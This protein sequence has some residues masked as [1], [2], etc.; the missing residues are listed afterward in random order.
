MPLTSDESRPGT[1]SARCPPIVRRGRSRW[2][3][4]IG[5]RMILAPS[6]PNTS[7]KERVNF[8]SL[9]QIR[10]SRRGSGAIVFLDP[11]GFQDWP[12]GQAFLNTTHSGGWSFVIRAFDDRDARLFLP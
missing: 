10:R 9:S 11:T 1:P 4:R 2:G 12:R 8:V 5:V 3:A 7:S 6:A